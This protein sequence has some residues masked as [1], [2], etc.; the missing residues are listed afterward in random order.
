MQSILVAH[1]IM[2]NDECVVWKLYACLCVMCVWEGVLRMLW[3]HKSSKVWVKQ[4]QVMVK[5]SLQEIN[6]M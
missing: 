2:I 6:V 5:L 1:F 4:V 3:G